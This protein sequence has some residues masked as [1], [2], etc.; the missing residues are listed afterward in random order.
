MKV[1]LNCITHSRIEVTD[2]DENGEFGRIL[3]PEEYIIYAARVSSPDNRLNHETAPK[4]LKYLID[5]KHWSPFEMVSIGI[6]IVT[7]RAI[8]QQILR[9]RSNSFQEFSQ[10]YAEATQM[11]PVQLRYQSEKNRQSSSNPVMDAY[12][13]SLVEEALEVCQRNYKL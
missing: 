3:T 5:H 2:C 8:A 4:L 1:T 7:S 9:H 12:C 10:R 13:N 6:E 11:E